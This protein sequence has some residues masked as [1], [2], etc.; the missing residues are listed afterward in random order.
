[1]RRESRLI[2]NTF[3]DLSKELLGSKHRPQFLNWTKSW[4]V[5]AASRLAEHVIVV[6]PSAED[7]E[8]MQK[9]VALLPPQALYKYP[10]DRPLCAETIGI[11]CFPND[12]E[13]TTS[14]NAPEYN[15]D[16]DAFQRWLYDPNAPWGNVGGD[17]RN[18]F[19]LPFIFLLS[20]VSALG[21]NTP[22]TL[23]GVCITV[24]RNVERKG[25]RVATVPY[26]FCILAEIPYVSFYFAM[27][28]RIASQ[29]VFQPA[30]PFC[31]DD[32]VRAGLTHVVYILLVRRHSTSLLLGTQRT[33]AT[34][35]EVVF[36]LDEIASRLYRHSAPEPGQE[37]SLVCNVGC[38]WH[39]LRMNRP[40]NQE[41]LD[42]I[43][44]FM[45]R[46]ALPALLKH[47][48][49]D[50]LLLILGC[51]LTEMRVVI[52]AEDLHIL[53]ACVFG[54]L[55]LLQPLSWAGPVIVTLPHSL[56]AYLES[57]VPLILGVQTLPE[58]FAMEP[59]IVVIYP[60][61]NKV[62]QIRHSPPLAAWMRT[63]TTVSRYN[64]R[65][66]AG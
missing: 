29:Q 3:L 43:T 44:Y 21:A 11:F 51:S 19:G 4:R 14:A 32:Q 6:G 52:V 62:R 60:T 63:L 27:L 5:P 9:P 16:F 8:A 54:L 34:A 61:Q 59:G 2:S 25:G 64:I 38:F 7:I 48:S 31:A 42:E 24:R 40:S 37:L 20:G 22:D 55:L 39:D 53:S 17:K 1:V 56:S 41:S 46:W 15:D 10:P 47:V 36:K 45:G 13:V 33:P 57:P 18:D 65:A 58:C 35:D 49:V 26:C 28:A 50:H 12:C 30:S 23:Y 66:H